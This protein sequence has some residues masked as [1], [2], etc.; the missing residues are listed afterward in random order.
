MFSPHSRSVRLAGSITSA[1]ATPHAIFVFNFTNDFFF[2][3]SASPIALGGDEEFMSSG[4]L[5]K[6]I[7]TLLAAASVNKRE[8]SRDEIPQEG[9]SIDSGSADRGCQSDREISSGFHSF[10]VDMSGLCVLFNS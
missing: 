9:R 2:S 1:R 8:T 3:L 7:H 4:G 10:F 6:C 5:S